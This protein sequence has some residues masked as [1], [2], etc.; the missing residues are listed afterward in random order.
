MNGGDFMLLLPAAMVYGYFFVFVRH[1][2][3]ERPL[4][5]HGAPT[6]GYVTAQTMD[7]TPSLLI[8]AFG[9]PMAEDFRWALQRGFAVPL[10]RYDCAGFLRRARRTA[11][12]SARCLYDD[13]RCFVDGR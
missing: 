13:N 4:L 11:Q 2:I 10:R 12:C 6:T 7:P 1:R 3:R 5:A 9:A 8:I